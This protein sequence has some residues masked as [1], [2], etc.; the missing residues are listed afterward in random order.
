MRDK[1]C[2][3]KNVT[4]VHAERAIVSITP[5]DCS[6]HGFNGCVDCPNFVAVVSGKDGELCVLCRRGEIGMAKEEWLHPFL[7]GIY[8]CRSRCPRPVQQQE[9]RLSWSLPLG[10]ACPCR[11]ERFPPHHA[12]SCRHRVLLL[13]SCH[14]RGEW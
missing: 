1:A 13:Q 4:R 7:S 2:S 3:K 8:Q 9:A 5:Y 6:S 14:R 11:A 12:E 10:R